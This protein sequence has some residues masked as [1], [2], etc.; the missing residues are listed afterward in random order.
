MMTSWIGESDAER[1]RRKER[2][3]AQLMRKLDAMRE[4]L[5]RDGIMITANY[6]IVV[7]RYKPEDQEDD[8]YAD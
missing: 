8:G 6:G 5:R 4:E 1:I 7:A 2:K 3:Q